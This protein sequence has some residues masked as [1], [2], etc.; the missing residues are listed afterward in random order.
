MGT[1]PANELKL[2]VM[3]RV[4]YIFLMLSSAVSSLWAEEHALERAFSQ[5]NAG[6]WQDALRLA[7]SDGAVARD[8][9][10][11]HRLRDG[12][13]TAQEA[14]KFLDRNGDW[15]GLPYLRKQSE[16]ALSDANEQTILTYFETSAPQTGAGALA[17]ALALSKDGQSNKAALVVQNA[18][19]TLPLKAPQQDAFLSA[20]GSVLA[21]LHELRL[22]EMLWMDEHAS[23]Q[24]MEN[25]VGT[26]LSALLRA[27][28]ALR[29]GQEGVTALIN[30][31]PN[32]L[33]NHPVLNHARFEWRL[34]NGFRDSA[35]DLLSVSSERASRLGQS[36]RWADTRIRIV[37]DLLFD[38]KNKQAYTLA[39][40]HHIAEGTKYAKLEW[41]AGFAALRRLSDP[42]RA[43]KHFK[44][45]LSAVD[46]PISLGRAYYW[47]GRAHAASGNNDAAL[48]A[49]ENGAKY[50]SSFYGLLSAE[51]ANMPM[52]SNFLTWGGLPDWRDASFV[53]SSVLHAA[54]LLFSANQNPLGE[55]FI[56]H[57]SETLGTD[58]VHKLNDFL[59][60]LRKPHVLV[61]LG[62]R[63][64]SMG[65]TF[66][67]PYYALHPVA[68]MPARV[69]SELVLAI[70]RRESEFDPYV[71]SPVGARGL[72]QVMPKTAKEM[73]DR[74]GLRYS[75]KRLETDW[76]YNARIGI[77]Y[78]EELAERYAGNPVLMSVAYNAGPSRADRWIELMG[79]PRKSEVDV[80]DWIEMA[81][82]QETRNYIMRVTESLP[83][84]QA[85]L[86]K[87]IA[88]K[89]FEAML[90]GSSLS[91]RTP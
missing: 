82:F 35:I 53:N 40:N 23:A 32:A 41:L 48:A 84:Y 70:A 78:L 52:P 80:I 81:P 30:A 77:T 42:K 73:A 11:W 72:M 76:A 38:G 8:I 71:I 58:D 44:N 46:T 86:G 57:L 87:A 50:Q 4:F 5:M 25:L 62:K 69:P 2:Q 45:F 10:E 79:D 18:W 51:K 37:R 55:R 43:V 59:E 12:Q 31:V 36:E 91:L 34:K 61:M 27:R 39:A 64:A 17:Y 3:F 1:Y 20:F 89:S 15:P 90:K 74:V 29:K 22:I 21:P 9:I 60:E 14:L 6:N 68:R 19:I 13:G 54:I 85:R 66:V 26:D 24:Q 16:V 67:R 33:G 7:Q 63:Q 65:K 83:I 49:Y 47:L 75:Q 88:P 28:I 56:T